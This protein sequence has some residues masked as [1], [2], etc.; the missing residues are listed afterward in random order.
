M[1]NKRMLSLSIITVVVLCLFSLNAFAYETMRAGYYKKN[2]DIDHLSYVPE[3]YMMITYNAMS[4]WNTSD[5]ER[6]V[7]YAGTE[8]N[9]KIKF[10][11]NSSEV[12]KGL[13]EGNNG[14]L[15]PATSFTIKIDIADLDYDPIQIR[16]TIA[17]EIGHAFGLD[18]TNNE[19]L[20][21]PRRDRSKVY[22][23]T[24]DDF[25]GVNSFY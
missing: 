3:E 22:K 25:E 6:R 16:S 10:V 11:E 13:Y 17:H 9:N 24:A 4:S 7:I 14:N 18:H 23:P 8:S 19:S 12:N 1:K 21:D 5:N 15:R 20:M 2:I